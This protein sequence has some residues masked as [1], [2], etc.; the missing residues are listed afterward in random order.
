MRGYYVRNETGSVYGF[1]FVRVIGEKLRRFRDGIK[2]HWLLID[3]PI[4]LYF[5]A[6]KWFFFSFLFFFFSSFLEED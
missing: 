6:K 1:S 5:S 2:R 4:R 3:S